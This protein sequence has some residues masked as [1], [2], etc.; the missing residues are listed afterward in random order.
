MQFA[1]ISKVRQAFMLY[2]TSQYSTQEDRNRLFQSFKA[3]DANNDG[4]LSGEEL[5]AGWNKV[6]GAA[7]SDEELD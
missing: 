6:F 5:K 4:K 3:L 1:H 2:V 7:L